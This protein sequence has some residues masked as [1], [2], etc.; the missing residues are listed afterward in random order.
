MI[1]LLY[2]TAPAVAYLFSWVNPGRSLA[3]LIITYSL[4]AAYFTHMFHS[5]IG[6]NEFHP[7][8]RIMAEA[9]PKDPE[10]ER[11]EE[12]KCL[13]TRLRHDLRNSISVIM[14]FADL[15]STEIAGTLNKKQQMYVHNI[16][17]GARQMLTLVDSKNDPNGNKGSLNSSA[18]D[19]TAQV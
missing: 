4:G 18:S 10:H 9:L 1:L 3:A 7:T 12:T 17:A 16:G 14:G 13:D 5:L 6:G 2:A 11:T 15:L 8:G 19:K